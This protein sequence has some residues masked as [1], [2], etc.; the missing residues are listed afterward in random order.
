M[1]ETN[2]KKVLLTLAVLF[3]M[4][5]PTQAFADSNGTMVYLN[6]DKESYAVQLHINEQGNADIDYSYAS[7]LCRLYFHSLVD[8]SYDEA[9]TGTFVFEDIKGT[10]DPSTH[11]LTIEKR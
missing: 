1:E 6:T 2:M 10:I 8:I 5:V 11:A 3:G 9:G 7:D 4:I